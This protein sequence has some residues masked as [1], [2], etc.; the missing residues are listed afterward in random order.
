MASTV[1]DPTGLEMVIPQASY[2]TS[3][4]MSSILDAYTSSDEDSW[5]A[6][7]AGSSDSRGGSAAETENDGT[8]QQDSDTHNSQLTSVVRVDFFSSVQL[9]YHSILD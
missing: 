3:N 9:K 6:G 7:Q 2:S 4:F 1:N 5:M 8:G